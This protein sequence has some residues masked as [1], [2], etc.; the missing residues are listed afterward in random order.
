MFN[1]YT[2]KVSER[3]KGQSI[4]TIQVKMFKEWTCD[5]RFAEAEKGQ[6][7]C[8][9][10]KK[11]LL[12]WS[13]INGSTGEMLIANDSITVG[14]IEEYVNVPYKFTPY[15]IPIHEFKTGMREFCTCYRQVGKYEIFSEIP[16]FIQ[17]CSD[18]EI[19]AFIGISKFTA[20]ANKQIT[21]YTIEKE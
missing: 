1:S 9:F 21:K 18:E 6:Q 8:L 20:Q 14:G 2:F 19:S 10:L 12:G 17:Q 5:R 4:E 15:C 16:R 11:G 3:L 7:L 13:I